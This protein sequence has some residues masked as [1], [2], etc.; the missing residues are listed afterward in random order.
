MLLNPG[1][2]GFNALTPN[3]VLSFV[4]VPATILFLLKTT[5][6]LSEVPIKSVVGFVPALPVNAHPTLP[7]AGVVGIQLVPFQAKT[8]P[9]VG[10]VLLTALPCILPT[11]GA[12]YVPLRS[13]PAVPFGGN[14]VGI[15][16]GA[17]LAAVTE[18]STIFIVEIALLFIV[19][20]GYVPFKS[21]PAVPFGGNE[22]GITPGAILA[23]VTAASTIFIVDIALLFIVGLGYVPFKSPPAVPPGGNDVGKGNCAPVIILPFASTVNVE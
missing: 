3:E 21:P 1:D 11:T 2:A 6:V 14:E 20:L 9:D 22:V 7:A 23:A 4:S 5:F 16:P 19:G 10:A 13:P 8:W 12:G 17:I 15:T 18:A